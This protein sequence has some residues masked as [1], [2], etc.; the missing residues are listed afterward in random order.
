M[1]NPEKIQ[2]GETR[3]S[4]KAFPQQ[5]KEIIQR[6]IDESESDPREI[7]IVGENE[8]WSLRIPHTDLLLVNALP[9]RYK[10]TRQRFSDFID[11]LL[12]KADYMIIRGA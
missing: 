1:G 11:S 6:S 4:Q 8:R 5:L 3:P 9:P 10:E 2:P 7:E 12:E